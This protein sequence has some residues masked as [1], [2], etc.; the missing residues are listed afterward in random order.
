MLKKNLVQSYDLVMHV[1]IRSLIFGALLFS[2]VISATQAADA[3][4]NEIVIDKEEWRD[5]P[6]RHLYI[7]GIW[8]KDTAFQLML[9]ERSLWRNRLIH[10]LEGALGG[11][12][13]FGVALG[14][15]RYALAN[16]AVYVESSQG[17][18][19]PQIYREQDTAA[20]ISYEASYAVVQYAKTR[21]V[22]LYAREPDFSYISGASGGGVRSTGLLERFPRVYDGALPLVGAGQLETIWYLHSLYENYRPIIQSKIKDV[23]DLARDGDIGKVENAFDTPEQK[24]A[25]RSIL[26]AGY[27]RGAIY[28]IQTYPVGFLML[29]FLK[30]KSDPAY[31]DEF[32]TTPG[33]GGSDAEIRK[34]VVEGIEG[35]IKLVDPK[36]YVLITDPPPATDDLAGYTLVFTSGAAKGGWW[37]IAGNKGPVMVIMPMGP[38]LDA[39]Q[40]GDRFR[41]DNRDLLAWRSYY[42]YIAKPDDPGMKGDAKTSLRRPPAAIRDTEEP[43]RPIGRFRG[44]MIMVFAGDDPLMWPSVALRYQR[45]VEKALGKRLDEHFRLH[46]IEHTVHGR[47][48]SV[49]REVFWENAS[50]KAMDDL[51]G[52]VEK[53]VSPPP[54]TRFTSG[55]DQQIILPA[56]ADARLG[57]QPVASIKADKA[58]KAGK[59]GGSSGRLETAPG[60]P[61]EFVVSAAD[62]DNQLV[63]LEIDFQGDNKFDETREVNAKTATAKFT[64]TYDKP[65]TYFAVVRVTDNSRSLGGPETGVQ[66]LA[67]VRI[68]VK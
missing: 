22:L 8:N 48:A 7:H 68:V 4:E 38:L 14:W 35:A 45:Q 57:Y 58:G 61:V 10:F 25:F 60:K 63:R 52:W 53:G 13:A 36:K 28:Q 18:I 43:D 9:P 49:N 23:A 20:E 66:N 1:A 16:G 34:Q 54:G 29:D 47:P 59:V 21:C 51:I 33:Y 39:V 31:F 42:R 17:H 30:Y 64:Y 12:E 3:S 44:K 32:W 56:T 2:G 6:S 46:F 65:G 50:F 15:H 55:T 40:P 24:A 11:S 26:G 27:P 19:G 41:L 5:Q 62:P 37:R 67:E